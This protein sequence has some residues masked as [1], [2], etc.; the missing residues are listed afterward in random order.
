MK[1]RVCAAILCFAS[2]LFGIP[3]TASAVGMDNFSRTNSYAD[4][5][6]SDVIPAAWY[7]RNIADAYEYGLMNG[8]SDGKFDPDGYVTMGAAAAMASRLHG[9]YHNGIADFVQ[10][11]PWYAVY[12][13]YITENGIVEAGQFADWNANATRRDFCAIMAHALPSSVFAAVGEVN[14]IPDVQPT[15]RFADEIFTLYRAG[16]LNGVDSS[17]RFDPDSYIKRSEVAAVLC[18]MVKL[19]EPT[20]EP[21]AAPSTVPTPPPGVDPCPEPSDEPTTEPDTPT[22]GVSELHNDRREDMEG[23][24]TGLAAY[25][26][27]SNRRY[28]ENCAEYEKYEKVDGAYV[29]YLTDGGH[30]LCDL[31][32]PEV[33]A[34][35]V[36]E[37]AAFVDWRI[38]DPTVASL[39]YGVCHPV[40]YYA[41]GCLYVHTENMG[42]YLYVTPLK[43][44]RTTITASTDTS[45]YSFELLVP[46]TTL[47]GCANDLGRS[48]VGTTIPGC[49]LPIDETYVNLIDFDDEYATFEIKVYFEVPEDFTGAAFT[50]NFGKGCEPTQT[51]I[52]SGDAARTGYSTTVVKVARGENA[53]YGFSAPPA[54]ER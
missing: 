34:A 31:Y 27:R 35:F 24:I 45:E 5:T 53:I 42:E 4:G 18:R 46:D 26:G 49:A 54:S 20:V 41:G 2:L 44:G 9:I 43:P 51:V 6:F 52:D 23:R 37:G 1:K 40:E 25:T 17:G 28:N 32:H 38:D 50:L 13:D 7:A 29:V 48:R 10:G 36:T 8:V 15:D 11:S 47:N 22:V 19:R 39:S 30:S 33:K 21:S 14:A 3:A 12:V 16:I